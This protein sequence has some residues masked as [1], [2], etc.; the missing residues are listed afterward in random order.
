MTC[1]EDIIVMT[2]S[3]TGYMENVT[4][5]TRDDDQINKAL[6]INKNSQINL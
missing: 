2:N 1:E 6:I 4:I 3:R 5:V